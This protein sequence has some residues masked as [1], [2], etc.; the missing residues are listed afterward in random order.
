MNTTV[1]DRPINTLQ[2]MMDN[3]HL[4]DVLTVYEDGDRQVYINA[5][6]PDKYLHADG[7]VRCPAGLML[8]SEEDKAVEA[9]G[10]EA[11]F[12]YLDG[13]LIFDTELNC[14]KEQLVQVLDYFES[15]GVQ[16]NRADYI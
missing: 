5:K 1:Y 14:T 16:F 12:H 10:A 6:M 7:S 9:D 8:F 15:F 2:A 11:V 3:S 13:C 4:G